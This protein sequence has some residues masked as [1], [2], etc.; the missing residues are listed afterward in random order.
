MKK[1]ILTASSDLNHDRRMLR[2]AKA[3]GDLGFEVL[4]LG[5]HLPSSSKLSEQPFFQKRLKCFFHKGKLFYL[6]FQLR[7]FFFLLF[8]KYDVGWAADLDTALP[9]LL[10]KKL[11]GKPWVYDAHEY[12]TEVPELQGRPWSKRVW[13]MVAGFCIPSCDFAVTVGVS[14]AEV[15]SKRYRKNFLVLRNLPF[16]QKDSAVKELGSCSGAPILLYQ[17]ALNVGRGLPELLEVLLLLP[18]LNLWLAGE[19]DLSATLRQKCKEL[20]LERRVRFWGYVSPIEL[21]ALA[22]KATLGLDLLDTSSLNYYYSLS[23][24]SMDY[25]QAGLPSLEMDFPEYR[26]LHEA[27]GVYELVSDLEPD[28]IA[29][30]V[31]NLLE[32]EGKYHRLSANALRAARHLCW[33][34]EK[35]KLQF[36]CVYL[37]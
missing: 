19:G 25:L 20:G 8:S 18:D 21:P 22:T 1:I 24:K 34:E 31:C 4:L 11:K 12:F 16:L 33:E 30:A 5:R 37:S 3:V 27:W 26:K 9:H 32:D 15:L 23:N 13:E 28:T 14:L 10:M 35:E 36:L 2:I 17:G 7:L 29:K 6:E